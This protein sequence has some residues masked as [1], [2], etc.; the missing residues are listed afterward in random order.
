VT[1]W[2]SVMLPCYLLRGQTSVT[3]IQ[4]EAAVTQM[5]RTSG[6]TLLDAKT[7]KED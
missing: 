4:H 3:M 1:V 7:S 2:W 5:F 6:Q